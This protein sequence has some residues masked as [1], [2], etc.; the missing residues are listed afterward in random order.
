MVDSTPQG[1]GLK[2]SG[3][4][5]LVSAKMS[6]GGYEQQLLAQMVG[7]VYMMMYQALMIVATGRACPIGSDD[8]RGVHG[9]ARPFPVVHY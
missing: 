6:Q 5:E 1:Y 4:W 2:F 9:Y 8:E 7:K 3:I